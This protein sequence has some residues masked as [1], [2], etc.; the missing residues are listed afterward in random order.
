MSVA[1][2]LASRS[3]RRLE[4]L[5]SIGLDP[6]VDPADIDETP[7][8]GEDPATY[9]E[10]LARTKASVVAD[11]HDGGIVVLGADTTIDLDNRI[12]GQPT[13]RD[14]AESMLSALSSRTHRV[15]TAVAVVDHGRIDSVVV[16]TLVTCVPITQELSRWY[17]DSGEWQGKAGSY[18]IQ[19]L[20][21][22]LV[23]RVVGSYSNVVGLPLRETARL[24][25]WTPPAGFPEPG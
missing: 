23:D 3:P 4:L 21:A 11:R 7:H 5:R 10:R 24:L 1:L 2:V 14:D 22:A 8:V 25:H 13:G 12:F 6:T 16:T 15:H 20:G 17:L 18:A 19:G 9:V